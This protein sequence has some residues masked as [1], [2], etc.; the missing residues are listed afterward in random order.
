MPYEQAHGD[1]GKEK[2][3]RIVNSKNAKLLYLNRTLKA[4][5]KSW[6]LGTEGCQLEFKKLLSANDLIQRQQ[7]LQINQSLGSTC[8][9]ITVQPNT[10]ILKGGGRDPHTQTIW[11]RDVSHKI[12]TNNK[13]H[14]YDH[15]IICY[16][17]FLLSPLSC[18][19]SG[20]KEN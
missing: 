5:T 4:I 18:M 13:Q 14:A 9:N 12:T 7:T 1:S 2:L 8:D 17:W 6:L 20:L 16:S 19:W 11:R 15:N 3:P 10:H